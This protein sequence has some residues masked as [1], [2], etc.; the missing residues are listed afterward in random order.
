LASGPAPT[1]VAAAPAAATAKPAAEAP[2]PKL[3]DVMLSMDV[4]DTLRHQEELVT[5]ELGEDQRESE[6]ID[7]LRNLYRNQGIEVP[8]RILEEGVKALK[9]SRFVYTPPLPSFGTRLARLWVGRGRI[10]GFV[11]LV[12]GIV[13]IAWLLHAAFVDWPKAKALKEARIEIS[14]TLP[15]ALEAARAGVR[16]ES[17]DIE[18]DAQADQLL[19]DGRNALARGDPATA[20]QAIASLQQLEGK[21]RLTY[22]LLIVARPGEPSAAF[23]IPARNQSARNYYLIVE[24][25]GPGGSPIALPITSEETGETKTV[26]KWGIRVPQEVFEAVRRDKQDDGIVQNRKV[27]EKQRGHLGVTYAMMVRSGAITEW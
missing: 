1:G 23:R 16:A 19:A 11:G 21:L 25:I 20:K 27:G 22:Q 26:T 12:L 2:R 18:A 7:R 13:A 10:G 4:V 9:E 14:E 5:R 3:D 6:L 24:A 17:R 15:K 8:D